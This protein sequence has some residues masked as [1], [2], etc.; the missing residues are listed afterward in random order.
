MDIRDVENLAQ[1]ARIELSEVEKKNLLLDLGGI[2]EYVKQVEGAAKA[3]K[4]KTENNIYN[5]WREDDLVAR[6]FSRE[7]ILKQF[8]DAKDGF[9]KVK[10]IL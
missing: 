2:L 10:K 7:L 3:E 6:Q 4:P 9:L 5:I 1:L 8:P